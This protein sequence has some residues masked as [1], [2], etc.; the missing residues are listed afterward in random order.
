MVSLSVDIYASFLFTGLHPD[1]PPSQAILVLERLSLYDVTE[2]IPFESAIVTSLPRLLYTDTPRRLQNLVCIIWRK[3]NM[4]MDEKYETHSY[5][6]TLHFDLPFCRL[7]VSTVNALS[8]EFEG[9]T[10]YSGE[11]LIADPLLVLKCDSKVF[12]YEYSEYSYE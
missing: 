7:W 5:S 8:S 1:T 12:R 10:C 4:V 2:L 6:A 3:L 11:R 9:K